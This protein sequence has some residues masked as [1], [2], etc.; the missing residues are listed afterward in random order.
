MIKARPDADP[1][2]IVHDAIRVREIPDYTIVRVF[3]R[4]LTSEISGEEQARTHFVLF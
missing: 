2:S 4:R 3:K 1:K